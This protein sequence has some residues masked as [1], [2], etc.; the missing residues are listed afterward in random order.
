MIIYKNLKNTK[1]NKKDI[2]SILHL[3]KQNWK[4]RLKSQYKYFND[5]VKPNDVHCMMYQKKKL[6]GY[7]LLRLR[8]IL[9]IRFLIFDTYIIC[10]TFRSKGNGKNLLLY[11]NKIIKSKKLPAILLCEKRMISFYSKYGWKLQTTKVNKKNLMSFNI[12][13]KKILILKKYVKKIFFSV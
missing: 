8:K 13:K 12:D 9:N 2:K 3:K 4:Y 11:D 10:K 1:I 5:N 6:I 7:T